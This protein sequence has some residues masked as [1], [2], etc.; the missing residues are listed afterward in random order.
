MLEASER[1]RVAVHCGLVRT[2]RK[3]AQRSNSPHHHFWN[4]LQGDSCVQ[5][6]AFYVTLLRYAGCTAFSQEEAH[7]YGAGDDIGTRCTMA[8]ADVADR[9][10][11]LRRVVAGIGLIGGMQAV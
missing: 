4:L 5:R 11:T 3:R 9:M 1:W 2:P 10:Q 6:D 8:L 7:V